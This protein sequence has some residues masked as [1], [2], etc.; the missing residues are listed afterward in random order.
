M[1]YLYYSFTI[2]SSFCYLQAKQPNII[3]I[4]A[5]DLG[6]GDLSCYGQQGFQTPNIDKLAEEGIKFT[7]HYSG[8][9]V[10]APS[11]SSLMTGQDS[12][13]TYI[14]GNG[15]YQLREKDLT[16]AELLKQAG[17]KTGMIG[18]S[19]VT[20]NT[21]DAQAPHISGFDYFWGTLSHKAA[22]YHYP[23]QVFTQG[24]SVEIAGN[25]GR[26]GSVY[27]QDRYTEK[28]LEFIEESKEDPFFLLL[29]FSVPHASLQAPEESV[30][31]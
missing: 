22:H 5:D 24:E 28:S 13:N 2:L 23:K 9:T 20:G 25:N 30:E 21:T 6:Y 11:R 29:S 27:I 15:E 19:C 10:C 31:P 8:S 4:I 14:R 16:V 1:R 3:Y 18:K 17:Y 26:T 12:G 7:S